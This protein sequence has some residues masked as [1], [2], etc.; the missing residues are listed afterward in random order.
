MIPDCFKSIYGNLFTFILV[1][2]GRHCIMSRQI[3]LFIY[4]Y[5]YFFF[6]VVVQILGN[7]VIISEVCVG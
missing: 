5:Y 1:R 4:Y 2:S 7:S 3:F 6:I